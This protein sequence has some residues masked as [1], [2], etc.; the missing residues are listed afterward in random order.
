ML[1][2][3]SENAYIQASSQRG[4]TL[5]EVLV[6]MALLGFGLAVAF[7]AVSGTARLDEKMS[8]HFAAMELA[9]SKLDETLAS[10]EFTVANDRGEDRFAG[11][12]FGYRIQLRPVTLLTPEQQNQ[13]RSFNT[14]L[15]RID[16]DVFWG[17][18]DAQ[19]VYSLSSYRIAPSQPKL[20]AQ[21]ESNRP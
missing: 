6:A 15:E 13:I 17:P 14:K 8:G 18:K 7:T 21:S 3:P 2:R 4:F 1:F 5:L 9:R 16:I 20:A 11:M 19:Q 10:P 12:D